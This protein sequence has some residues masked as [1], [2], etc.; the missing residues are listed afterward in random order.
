MKYV[1]SDGVIL[2]DPTL[3]HTLVGSL[4][5]LTITRTDISYAVHVVSQFFISSTIIHWAIVL[6]IL[7]GMQFQSL[8]F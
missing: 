5:Y 6:C 8:L 2:P 3:Y 1:S 7:R 4:V